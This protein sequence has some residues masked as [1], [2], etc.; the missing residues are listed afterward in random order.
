MFDNQQLGYHLDHSQSGFS[1]HH[2]L[3]QHDYLSSQ[4]LVNPSS[5]TSFGS[6][7]TTDSDLYMIPEP[8]PDS[9]ITATTDGST[10][11]IIS[12]L[13]CSSNDGDSYV[14]VALV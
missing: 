2:H 14:T 10:S 9:V 4:Y 13:N 1:S 6:S 5:I 7:D 8:C 3:Q 12:I 11:A